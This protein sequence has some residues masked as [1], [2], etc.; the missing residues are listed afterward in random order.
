MATSAT[1]HATWW[2]QYTRTIMQKAHTTAEC[3]LKNTNIAYRAP[4][5]ARSRQVNIIRI[6]RHRPRRS[7]ET[8][9]ISRLDVCAREALFVLFA[10]YRAVPFSNCR[11]CVCALHVCNLVNLCT[12]SSPRTA[13]HFVTCTTKINKQ[14]QWSLSVCKNKIVDR[15]NS[16]NY[17]FK[18]FIYRRKKRLDE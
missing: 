9:A 13:A 5:S 4:Q 18:L 11:S 2:L 1:V 8:H 17:I 14:Y 16:S 6:N 3:W 7:T 10:N 12:Q 15:T